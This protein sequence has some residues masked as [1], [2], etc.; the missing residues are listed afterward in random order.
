MANHLQPF[1]CHC[2]APHQFSHLSRPILL[3]RLV[4][5]AVN[6]FAVSL[7]FWQQPS[8]GSLYCKAFS[9]FRF[10]SSEAG[11]LSSFNAIWFL[12]S[13]SSAAPSCT[14][15]G[16][17]Q[18]LHYISLALW[19][20]SFTYIPLNDKRWMFYDI[21]WVVVVLMATDCRQFPNYIFAAEPFSRCLCVKSSVCL[22]P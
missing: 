2:T 3:M 19:I 8:Y 21:R 16:C 18:F 11:G 4:T 13:S 1:K 12:G 5:P 10:C 14:G 17:C 22:L 20:D 15:W 6:P 7:I 9:L